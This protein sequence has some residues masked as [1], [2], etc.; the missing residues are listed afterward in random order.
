MPSVAAGVMFTRN[1]QSTIALVGVG[2]P[3]PLF[4]RNQGAVARASAEMQAEARALEAELAE[5]RAELSRAH[6]VLE[7]RKG[8]LARLEHDVVERL[9]TVR[10]MAEDAYREGRGGILELLDAFRSLK[11]MRVLHLKQQETVKLA[12]ASVFF[13]AGLDTAP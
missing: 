1:E 10:R 12:E 3:L 8:A 9:P 4:D 6:A 11:D 5:A 7:G 13:A 2:L